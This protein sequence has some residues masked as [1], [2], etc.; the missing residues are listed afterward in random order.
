MRLQAIISFDVKNSMIKNYRGHKPGRVL[1]VLVVGSGGGLHTPSPE[2]EKERDRGDGERR[3]RGRGESERGA[4]ERGGWA[5]ERE[6]D[7]N[8]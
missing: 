7:S 4:S 1:V 3:E 8:N 2:R 6:R 5:T